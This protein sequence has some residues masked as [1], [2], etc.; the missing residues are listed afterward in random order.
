M[1]H[2]VLLLSDHLCNGLMILPFWDLPL[3]SHK[4]ALNDAM[5]FCYEP[6]RAYYII[7]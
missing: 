5:N 2:F 7:L 3:V 4:E 1:R 6:T